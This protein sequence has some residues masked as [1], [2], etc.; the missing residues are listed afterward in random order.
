M[1]AVGSKEEF[2]VP[3]LS[4]ALLIV[5]P[6]KPEHFAKNKQRPPRF[7]FNFFEDHE[8]QL[9]RTEQVLPRICLRPQVPVLPDARIKPRMCSVRHP[10]SSSRLCVTSDSPECLC[11][12]VVTSPIA[13][14]LMIDDGKA[15]WVGCCGRC[16]GLVHVRFR[17]HRAEGLGL[18]CFRLAAFLDARA[19]QL[20]LRTDEHQQHRRRPAA[21]ASV[22]DVWEWHGCVR[23]SHG[24][25]EG[26]YYRWQQWYQLCSVQ[27]QGGSSSNRN[28]ANDSPGLN[29]GSN[30]PIGFQGNSGSN[31]LCLNWLV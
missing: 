13:V 14:C 20:D 25:C 16:V 3:W 1:V 30:Q 9:Y 4:A 29:H 22:L 17:S 21:F 26:E 8:T 5:R 6:D 11:N 24:S 27:Q 12:T 18:I 10:P 28:V 31:Q 19:R 2:K 15:K 23:V 7:N